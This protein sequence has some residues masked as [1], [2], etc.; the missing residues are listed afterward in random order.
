M[1]IIK[2][3]KARK[4]IILRDNKN[5]RIKAVE[6]DYFVQQNTFDKHQSI[7][8]NHKGLTYIIENPS[9]ETEEDEIMTIKSKITIDEELN[10]RYFLGLDEKS[11]EAILEIQEEYIFTK[12]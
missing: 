5:K 1:K 10:N 7:F 11:K 9:K 2:F 3:D 6:L 4:E 12:Q 8:F